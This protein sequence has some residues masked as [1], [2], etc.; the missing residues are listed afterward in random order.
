MLNSVFLFHG[1]N[2]YTLRQ[3]LQRWK[4]SFLE[5][6]GQD[7]LFHFNSQNWDL[8]VIK[9]SLYAGGLFVSKKLIIIEG[10]P[11]DLAQDGGLSADKIESFFLDFQENHHLL[12]PDTIVIFLSYKPDKRTKPFK[13][14]SENTQVKTFDLYKE[15]QLKAFIAEQIQPFHLSQELI[16]YFLLK[17]GADLY[18]L[19][20]ELEKLKF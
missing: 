10:V 1:E 15:P 20:H 7:A 12:T 14:F 18:R 4:T 8:G 2:T 3:E 19:S 17:V 9:Q 11:K 5:K 13:W 6:Y 16:N